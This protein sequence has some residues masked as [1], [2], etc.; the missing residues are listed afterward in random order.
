MQGRFFSH[1]TIIKR[2]ATSIAISVLLFYPQGTL[3][4]SVDS[5]DFESKYPDLKR[6][7]HFEYFS[8]E[9]GLSSNDCRRLLV[10]KD[11][12]LWIGTQDGLNRFDGH[13]FTI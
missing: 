3:A 12:F 2:Y 1:S 11:G 9:Q 8:T 4:Q 6:V 5:L 7:Y 13:T 10:D